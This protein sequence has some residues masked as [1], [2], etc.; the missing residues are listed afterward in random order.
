V[1][2]WLSY[3]KRERNSKGPQVEDWKRNISTASAGTHQDG[4]FS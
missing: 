1:I 3:A 2:K 4:D